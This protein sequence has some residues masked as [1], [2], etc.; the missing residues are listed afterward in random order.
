MGAWLNL[1]ESLQFSGKKSEG[2]EGCF[3]S[4]RDLLCSP[5]QLHCS[6]QFCLEQKSAKLLVTIALCCQCSFPA[7]PKISG[8]LCFGE[9]SAY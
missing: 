4:G 2:K 5:F 1:G 9:N 7:L 8:S 6:S 3:K